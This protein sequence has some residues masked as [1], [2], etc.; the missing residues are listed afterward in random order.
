MYAR[1]YRCRSSY[2]LAWFE[3]DGKL[4]DIM[5]LKSS[6]M[7]LLTYNGYTQSSLARIKRLRKE[8][9]E[10]PYK[11]C[12]V[13][14]SEDERYKTLE[15]S[16]GSYNEDELSS[17]TR[18][19]VIPLDCLMDF[20]SEYLDSHKDYTVS[21]AYIYFIYGEDTHHHI[22]PVLWSWSTDS[23]YQKMLA[24]AARYLAEVF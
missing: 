23:P 10:I 4:L 3:D 17:R 24:T 8:W 14:T 2:L 9:E 20:I 1:T 15:S 6:G 19:K 22:R 18:K 13:I 12:L 21:I 7:G 5:A 11:P 16:W